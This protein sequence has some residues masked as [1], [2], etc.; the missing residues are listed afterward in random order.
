MITR[1]RHFK[2][3]YPRLEVGSVELTTVHKWD[4]DSIGSIPSNLTAKDAQLKNFSLSSIPE[5]GSDK[6]FI[7]PANLTCS[8]RKNSVSVSVIKIA[9]VELIKRDIFTRRI[10]NRVKSKGAFFICTEAAVHMDFK[11]SNSAFHYRQ[12][13]LVGAVCCCSLWVPATSPQQQ[14]ARAE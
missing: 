8:R 6:H 3:T 12:S 11:V 14:L 4:Q 2:K 1:S 13:Y 5:V 9:L 10:R 7:C